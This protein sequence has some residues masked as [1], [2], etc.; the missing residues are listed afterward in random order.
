M[1]CVR[2]ISY[3]VVVNGQSAGH[4]QPTRGTCQGDPLAPYF[5]IL[6]PE[7]LSALLLQVE[8]S[9]SLTGVPTSKNR[10]RISHLF[11]ADDNV[12]YCPIQLAQFVKG[13]R[14]LL[15]MLFG[16]T[17]RPKMLGGVDR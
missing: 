5:F 6:C 16:P 13:M 11:F 3:V 15:F 12:L 17:Q 10:P 2:P 14:K 7:A 4:I 1:A 8:S 9:G